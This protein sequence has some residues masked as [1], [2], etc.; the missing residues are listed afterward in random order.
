[1]ITQTHRYTRD[2]RKARQYQYK[3]E[4]SSVTRNARLTLYTLKDNLTPSVLFQLI[5]LIVSFFV[6]VHPYLFLIERKHL[7]IIFIIQHPMLAKFQW[8]TQ[9]KWTN[10]NWYLSWFSIPIENI[11]LNFESLFQCFIFLSNLLIMSTYKLKPTPTPL[12]N[13]SNHT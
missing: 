8:E 9:T 12:K 7:I 5:T 13:I 10:K 6:S 4:K 3:R 2:N 1:M 11:S